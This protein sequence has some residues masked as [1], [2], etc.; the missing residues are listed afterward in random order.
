MVDYQRIWS[1]GISWGYHVGESTTQLRSWGIGTLGYIMHRCDS[2]RIENWCLI[3]S[4]L[5]YGMDYW[6]YSIGI[7]DG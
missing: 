6:D 7:D 2:W 3:P 4:C 1:D 5:V